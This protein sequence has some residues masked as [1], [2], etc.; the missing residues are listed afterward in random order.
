MN[1]C[2]SE[3]HLVGLKRGF[4]QP[5]WKCSQP[6]VMK[7]TAFGNTSD[8][9]VSQGSQKAFTLIELLVVIAIIA[10]LAGMLLPTLAKAKVRAQALDCMSNSRQLMLGWIQYTVDHND[11]IVNNFGVNAT[12][13]EI[14]NKTYGNWVNDV[15]DWTSGSYVTNLEGI[16]KAPFNTYV[17]GNIAIYKCPADHYLSSTQRFF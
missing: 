2:R 10:I 7:N 14:N 15:M 17:G 3:K 9:G 11:M 16:L 13:T 5:I 8:A 4:H 1:G 12:L 6:I